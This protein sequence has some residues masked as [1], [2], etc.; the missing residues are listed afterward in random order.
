MCTCASR[1]FFNTCGCFIGINQLP[2]TFAV[3]P[4]NTHWVLGTSTGP[5]IINC[6]IRASQSGDSVNWNVYRGSQDAASLV[7]KRTVVQYAFRTSYLA[8]KS[9]LGSS[10]QTVNLEIRHPAMTSDTRFSC[11]NDVTPVATFLVDVV[12][13]GRCTALCRTCQV[14]SRSANSHQFLSVDF[15]T[16]C[17][18]VCADLVVKTG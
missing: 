1:S 15:S 18:C 17:L 4:Q 6:K 7:V 3:A 11:Q 10:S 2:P 16:H 5:L 8:H 14:I 12:I 13:I 9:F